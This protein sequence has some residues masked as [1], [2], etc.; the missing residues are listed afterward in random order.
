VAQGFAKSLEICHTLKDTE[1]Q[2]VA[3]FRSCGAAGRVKVR[4]QP[5]VTTSLGSAELVV[6]KKIAMPTSILL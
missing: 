2:Q 4:E 3:G 1:N 6:H 5:T